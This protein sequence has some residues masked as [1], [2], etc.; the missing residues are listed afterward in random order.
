MRQSTGNA[1]LKCRQFG[2]SDDSG[3]SWGAPVVAGAF[4]FV[5]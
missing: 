1:T 4:P 2:V 3:E 5:G